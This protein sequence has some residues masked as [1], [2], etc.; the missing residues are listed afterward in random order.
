MEKKKPLTLDH[1]GKL[2]S[3]VLQK[4]RWDRKIKNKTMGRSILGD[5][6][7]AVARWRSQQII[8]PPKQIKNW[9]GLSKITIP[10]LWKADNTLEST[11]SWR[12]TLASGKKSLWPCWLGW[13]AYPIPTQQIRLVVL[14]ALILLENQPLWSEKGQSLFESGAKRW[15]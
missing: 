4:I 9:L 2:N 11:C 5:E 6:C 3:Q 7:P 1:K 14:P 10:G 12:A 13:A 15:R 8:T